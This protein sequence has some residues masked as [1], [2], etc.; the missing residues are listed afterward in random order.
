MCRLQAATEANRLGIN[1][2][3][4]RDAGRTQ[5]APGSKTVLCVG[6]GIKKDVVI[7]ALCVNFLNMQ[8]L[9]V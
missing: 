4:V 9:R 2:Y 5:I 6:P 7:A 1:T 3:I 8:G